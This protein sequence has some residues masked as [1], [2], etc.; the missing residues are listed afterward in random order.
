MSYIVVRDMNAV[1]RTSRGPGRQLDN[2]HLRSAFFLN[3]GHETLQVPSQGQP[4]YGSLSA[5]YI[6]RQMTT[7]LGMPGT[8]AGGDLGSSQGEGTIHNIDNRCDRGS[9]V[10]CGP[11]AGLAE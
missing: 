3:D 11:E 2:A 8:G 5:D 6:L 10:L 9:V 7:G 4:V 1:I